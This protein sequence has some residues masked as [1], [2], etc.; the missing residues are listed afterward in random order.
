MK[1]ILEIGTANNIGYHTKRVIF[2]TKEEAQRAFARQIEIFIRE[3]VEN[4]DLDAVDEREYRREIRQSE[5]FVED[6]EQ[7]WY[8]SME[9][10]QEAKDIK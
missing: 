8:V 10:A 6:P 3:T 1:Y 5:T 7:E 4:N 9:Q 2:D